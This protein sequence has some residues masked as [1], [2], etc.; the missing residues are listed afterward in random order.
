M[1]HCELVFLFCAFAF[2]FVRRLAMFSRVCVCLLFVVVLFV[3]VGDV[4]Y[5]VWFVFVVFL[6]FCVCVC[7]FCFCL[8][9]CLL[10]VCVVVCVVF[11]RVLVC[12][13]ILFCFV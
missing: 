8:C 4:L 6:M 10:W 1:L 2:R 3:S 5:G 11:F 12:W 7:S 13:F 9:G